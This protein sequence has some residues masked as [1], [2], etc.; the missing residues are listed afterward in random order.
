MNRRMTNKKTQTNQSS[1]KLMSIIELLADAQEPMRLL[2]ISERLEM[3]NS[4]ALRF[5]NSMV[6][7]GYVLQNPETL[8]YYLSYKIC[9]IANKVSAKTNIRDIAVPFLKDISRM[10]GE[11]VCLSIEQDMK[12]VYIDVVEGPDQMI[13]SMQRIGNMA[14]LHCTA[15]GKLFLTQYDYRQIDRLVEIVGLQKFTPNTLTSKQQLIKAVVDVKDKGYALDEEECEIGARCVGVPIRNY[16]GK[17]VACVSVTGPTTRLTNE[18]IISR[19][20][21]LKNVTN[22]ISGLLGYINK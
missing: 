5:L 19:I 7:C 18:F 12:V 21:D 1:E 16:T 22:E 14:P 20:D 4:T 8:K 6:K 11:S 13:R 2:D 3:N 9:T 17:I 15:V 10:F